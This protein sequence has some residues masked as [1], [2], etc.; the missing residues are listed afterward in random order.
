[1]HAGT[2]VGQFKGVFPRES[3]ERF[4]EEFA[5]IGALTGPTRDVDVYVLKMDDYRST[6]PEAVQR[7]LRPLEEFLRRHQEIE[8]NKLA[9]GLDSS[10]YPDLIRHW[11]EFLETPLP[12]DPTLPEAK[13]PIRE[14]A[15]E[16]IARCFRR[17][18]KKGRAID[19]DSPPEKLHRLRIECKKLRYLLEFFRSLYE[20]HDVEPVVK[21]LKRLQDNLGDFNDLQIQRKTLERFAHEMVAEGCATV[22]SLMAMGRLIE[23]LEARQAEA[24]SQFTKRFA[25]F[26]DLPTRE[27]VARVIHRPEGTAS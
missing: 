24:R 3:V 2:V 25:A 15:S 27:R 9:A 18:L 10:R 23:R 6:L 7:D 8:Q 16:R 22:E 14:V 13:R 11:R 20:P 21:S 26:D 4:R 17:V 1:V 12:D 5:W 19:D